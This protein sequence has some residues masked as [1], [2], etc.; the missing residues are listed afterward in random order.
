MAGAR[1]RTGDCHRDGRAADERWH[2]RKGGERFWWQ[3]RAPPPARRDGRRAGTRVVK[4]LRDET[5]RKQPMTP[6][7]EGG[8]ESAT[9]EG[10]VP[11][12]ALHELRTA[13]S[14]ILLW[15]NIALSQPENA[16][17]S[18]RELEG[19][20]EQRRGPEGVDRDLLDTSRITSGKV[21]LR[22]ATWTSGLVR[23]AI[24]DGASTAETKGIPWSR[25]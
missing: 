1:G 12:H 4:V 17:Q 11:R 14:A 25:N 10:R 13:L 18:G 15:V 7:E 24:R 19:D 22:G 6:S 20:Q 5:A 2:V 9:H 3:W 16:A 23:E 21:R 8:A